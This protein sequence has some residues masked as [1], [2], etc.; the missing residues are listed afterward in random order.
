MSEQ[1]IIVAGAGGHA[2]VVIETIRM[3]GN[4]NIVGLVDRA[5]NGTYSAHGV[6]IIG[7]DESFDKEPTVKAITKLRVT[8]PRLD[9]HFKRLDRFECFTLGF[10]TSLDLVFGG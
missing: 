3:L 7:T 8:V 10:F 9:L 1:N 5:E 6:P 2:G 4:Y